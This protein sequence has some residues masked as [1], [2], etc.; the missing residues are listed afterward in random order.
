MKFLLI[1]LFL[2]T[3]C[4]LP[5][6][7]KQS[8]HNNLNNSINTYKNYYESYHCS[9]DLPDVNDYKVY[10]STKYNKEGVPEIK[11]TVKDNI[12]FKKQLGINFDLYFPAS[13]LWHFS[14]KKNYL[15]ITFKESERSLLTD[16]F[17]EKNDS[18]KLWQQR[19]DK[20]ND[21]NDFILS[22]VPNKLSVLSLKDSKNY[23][24]DLIKNKKVYYTSNT[25]IIILCH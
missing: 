8:V 18:L 6:M 14:F 4:N 20:A 3:S 25:N 24:L 21:F 15:L 9:F 13:G 17:I 22:E 12:V 2:I 16:S 11:V 7:L 19:I 5:K 10:F 1:F 23:Y